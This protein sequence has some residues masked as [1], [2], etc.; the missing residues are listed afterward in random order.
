MDAK[1]IS[2]DEIMGAKEITKATGFTLL[3]DDIILWASRLASV[4]PRSSSSAMIGS[5]T[6]AR[7]AS[8]RM[9]S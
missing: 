1:N 2:L 8:S 6:C 3:L 7:E 9:P 5:V 4:F